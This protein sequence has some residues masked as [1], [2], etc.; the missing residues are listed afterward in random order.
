MGFYLNKVRFYSIS[1]LCQP[2]QRE[3]MDTAKYA[4]LNEIFHFPWSDVVSG[5][6]Q[7]YPNKYSTHVL[8]EDVI[9][10]EILEDGSLKTI[11]LL[12]KTNPVP[13]WGKWVFRNHKNV[14][15]LV[16]ESIVSPKDEKM[17]VY[18]HNI[19]Y[20][21]VMRT[22]EKLTI[23]PRTNETLIVREGWVDSTFKGFRSLL[24]NFGISR[25]KANSYKSTQGFIGTLNKSV[26]IT[27]LDKS[28]EPILIASSRP[29]MHAAKKFCDV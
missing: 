20:K 5:F 22:Y 10:R 4:K 13:S 14:V 18:T 2:F 1:Y 3:T 26:A 29:L 27:T 17:K 25:W 23:T 9:K 6:W 21:N 8:S 15:I 19:S 16:E 7:K 28:V 12:T 11:R 24:K